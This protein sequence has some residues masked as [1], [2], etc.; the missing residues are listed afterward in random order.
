MSSKPI[1]EIRDLLRDINRDIN[2]MQTEITHIKEYI[3]KDEVRKSLEDDKIVEM[4]TEY[5]NENK[6]WW[7]GG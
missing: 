4:E 5:V 6:S 3:R 2:T 7:F 1:T